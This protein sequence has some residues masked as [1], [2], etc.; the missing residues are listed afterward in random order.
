MESHSLEHVS[1]WL[2]DGPSDEKAFPQALDWAFRLNMSL[3]AVITSRRLHGRC[4]NESDRM[5][6]NQGGD[7]I[8]SPVVEKM[9]TW[10]N[11]C[12]E[13]GVTLEMFL[14][15]GDGDAG[16]HQFLRP[17]GLC[18]C[19]NDGS[20]GIHEELW[21]RDVG[22]HDKA[23]LWCAPACGPI[24]RILVLH[25]QADQSAAFLESGARFCQALDVRP[26]VL[27]AAKTEREARRRQGFVEGFCNSFGLAADFDF[28]V[29]CDPCAAASHVA[30]WRR[31]SHLI[32]ERPLAASWRQR[33]S[34]PG[35][36]AFRGLPDSVSV[37]TLPEAIVL[38]V[39][40]KI[41]NGSVNRP[42]KLL[43]PRHKNRFHPEI[44]TK[45]TS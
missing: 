12:G 3:R 30:S 10:G 14:W 37:L 11:A 6:L 25:D 45:V 1:V 2:D 23:V 32:L 8:P 39:P 13:R 26:V 24:S 20:S 22:S 17:H 15:L 28:V 9:K 31:C 27:I 42:W 29:G 7:L 40:Q 21:R 33:H 18:V 44:S 5:A 34:G 36:N 19:V 16:L 38:D 43:P 4:R 35:P 41:L